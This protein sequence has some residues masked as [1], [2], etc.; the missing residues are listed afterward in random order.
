MSYDAIQGQIQDRGAGLIRALR[1]GQLLYDKW[2]S[3]TY[4][5]T[6]E[7]ILALPNMVGVS[8]AEL[9]SMKYAIGVFKALADGE[10][11]APATRDAYLVPFL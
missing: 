6:D 3:Y 11:L 5:L 1:D 4:G 7:Q 10:A 2:Y 9:T 8:Q